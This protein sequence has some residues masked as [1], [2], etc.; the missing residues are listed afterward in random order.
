MIKSVKS[1][2]MT[3][4]LKIRCQDTFWTVHF[5]EVVPV[6]YCTRTPCRIL[7]FYSSRPEITNPTQLLT[8]LL[9]HSR[10]LTPQ[11]VWPTTINFTCKTNYHR[12]KHTNQS[13]TASESQSMVIQMAIINSRRYGF[14]THALSTPY[15]WPQRTSQYHQLSSPPISP[16]YVYITRSHRHPNVI[17]RSTRKKTPHKCDR[18]TTKPCWTNASARPSVLDFPFPASHF[19]H[20]SLL[21]AF[22]MRRLCVYEW[23]YGCV[24]VY[25]Y[26]YVLVNTHTHNGHCVRWDVCWQTWQGFADDAVSQGDIVRECFPQSIAFPQVK[27]DT[28]LLYTTL[29]QASTHTLS[30]RN[31]HMDISFVVW[32]RYRSGIR[33]TQQIGCVISMNVKLRM[34]SGNVIDTSEVIDCV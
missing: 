8:Y 24:D 15:T 28:F 30:V 9:R 27:M 29:I 7:L 23:K 32:S 2:K 12:H 31:E 14:H 16:P 3:L 25:W 17:P 10:P 5:V 1:S 26:M 13:L 33:S 21:I 18:I 19:V 20:S 4:I 6:L 11:R 34:K 22:P